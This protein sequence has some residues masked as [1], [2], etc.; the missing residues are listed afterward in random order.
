MLEERI[1]G[2]GRRVRRVSIVTK[3]NRVPRY[4]TQKVEKLRLRERF[5]LLG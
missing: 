5:T 4:V 3:C 1:S 2:H